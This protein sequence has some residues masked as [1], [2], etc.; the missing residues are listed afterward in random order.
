MKLIKYLCITIILFFLFTSCSNDS[1]METNNKTQYVYE[2]TVFNASFGCGYGILSNEVAL[3]PNN[4]TTEFQ[5]EGLKVKVKFE[6]TGETIDCG[7]FLMKSK[8]IKIVNV[9]KIN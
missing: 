2:G 9:Q 1:E 6:F 4:L 7:G 8:K 3:I 5:Q